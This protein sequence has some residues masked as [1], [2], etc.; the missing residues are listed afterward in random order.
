MKK[1]ESKE[2]KINVLIDKAKPSLG[3][4][5]LGWKPPYHHHYHQHSLMTN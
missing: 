4:A 2:H 5:G 1:E 3:G